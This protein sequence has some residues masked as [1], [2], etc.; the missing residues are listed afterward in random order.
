MIKFEKEI[1]LVNLNLLKY[2]SC[3]KTDDINEVNVFSL[4]FVANNFKTYYYVF[5]VISTDI[6]K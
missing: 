6:S 3:S 2:Y 5:F 1:T 4:I